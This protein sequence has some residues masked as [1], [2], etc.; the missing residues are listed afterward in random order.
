[1]KK[2][3]QSALFSLISDILTGF[4]TTWFLATIAALA[5]GTLLDL[6]KVLIAGILSAVASY[7]FR[8]RL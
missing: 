7:F 3:A 5:L 1:M 8:K 2:K 6:L 4:A